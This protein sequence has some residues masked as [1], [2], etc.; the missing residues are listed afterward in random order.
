[1][2]E[3]SKRQYQ[4]ELQTFPIICFI[5]STI[6]EHLYHR[7]KM[8]VDMC[9]EDLPPTF[10]HFRLKYHPINDP[11]FSRIETSL[12]STGIE[13]FIRAIQ[14]VLNS[15]KGKVGKGKTFFEEAFG[16]DEHRFWTILW[17]PETFIIYRFMFKDNLAKE[18]EEKLQVY[19]PTS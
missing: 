12:E 18:W 9:D 4:T 11:E 1:M 8:N 2:K 5:I 6:A 3:Q 10:V 19:L 17:M 15:T 16:A 7:M 13:K 14:A